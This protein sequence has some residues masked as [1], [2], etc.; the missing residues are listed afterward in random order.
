MSQ[1]MWIHQGGP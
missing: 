1:S